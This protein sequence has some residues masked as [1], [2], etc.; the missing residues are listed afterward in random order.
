[1]IFSFPPNSHRVLSKAVKDVP[2]LPSTNPIGRLLRNMMRSTKVIPQY[3]KVNDVPYNPN[4]LVSENFFGRI[5]DGRGLKIHIYVVG[6][7]CA[8][9]VRPKTI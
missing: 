8:Q 6:H 5:Y 1:M 4:T 9:N 2:H 7:A 3:Y